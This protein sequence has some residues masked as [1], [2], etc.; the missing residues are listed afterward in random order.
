LTGRPLD[1]EV[2]VADRENELG[3]AVLEDR[4]QR[5]VGGRVAGHE[6]GD[7]VAARGGTGDEA[8]PRNRAQGRHG[9]G[10]LLEGAHL[11]EAL[12]V[13]RP[14]GVDEGADQGRIE[15]VETEHDYPPVGGRGAAARGGRQR[16]AGGSRAA[17]HQPDKVPAVDTAS[18]SAV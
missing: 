6:V 12:E 5:Q 11:G 17:G 14:A 16:Q 18:R 10:E 9:G 13:G 7:A 8:R 1:R 2:N 3:I 15:A 4:E